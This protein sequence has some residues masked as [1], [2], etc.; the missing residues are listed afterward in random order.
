MAKVLSFRMAQLRNDQRKK[1]FLATG[2]K[3]R[4]TLEQYIEILRRQKAV[5]E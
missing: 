4:V 5:N 3:R 1:I 2:T